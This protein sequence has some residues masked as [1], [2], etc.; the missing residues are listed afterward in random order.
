MSSNGNTAYDVVVIGG[1]PAGSTVSTLL[2]QRQYRVLV[3]EKERFPRFSIGESLMPGTYWTFKRLGMLEKLRASHFPRKY[4]V[5]FVS[6]SGRESQP[7]YFFQ[8]NPHESAV[9]WQVLRSE[10]DLM[11]LENAAEHGVD[12]WQGTLVKEVLFEGDRAVGVL[13]LK[14]GK[15]CEVRAKVVV[16]ASGRN[17]FLSKRLNMRHPDPQLKKAAVFA[18]YE[19]VI[20]DPGIDEGVTLVLNIR[21][22][23]GWFWYIPLPNNVVS[24][25]V[26]ANPSVLFEG[27]ARDPEKVL[28]EEIV[29]CPT[30]KARL[31]PARRVSPV[32]V[33]NDFSYRSLQ[34]SGHGW[35]LIGDAYGFLDPIYSSGVLLALKSGEFAADT[36][37]EAFRTG[38]FSGEQL[39]GFHPTMYRGIEAMRKLVYAFYSRNFSFGQFVRNHPEYQKN[40]VDLLVGDVFKPEAGE[41]FKVMSRYCD[42]PEPMNLESNA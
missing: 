35:V 33:L 18:H 2:A 38:D 31:V 41:I 34:P 8:T 25:G 28:E 3:I 24:I 15:P 10:F 9:T 23:L 39:G 5:Q 36:I 40:L 12:V 16:D 6:A 13:A 21:D 42:L 4:S 11:M 32:Q 26:V 20:R 17:A 7:F 27:R 22:N 1:G 14:D 37:H 29:L 19:N 30:V